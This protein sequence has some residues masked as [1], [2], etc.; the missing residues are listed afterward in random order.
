M[1]VTCLPTAYETGVMHVRTSSPSSSTEHEPHCAIPQPSRG[2]LNFSSL[3]RTKIRGVSGA[4]DTTCLAP[5]TNRVS[6][7]AMFF[8]SFAKISPVHQAGSDVLASMTFLFVAPAARS[9]FP[10]CLQFQPLIPLAVLLR[11]DTT[12]ANT[13]PNSASIVATPTSDE[14]RYSS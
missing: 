1:V 7:L 6:S 5:F 12:L 13:T 3:R 4:A 14:L 10:R 9:T 2:P 11:P 8:S